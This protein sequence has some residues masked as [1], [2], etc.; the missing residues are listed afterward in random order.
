MEDGI[1]RAG[2]ARVALT[3]SAVRWR[4]PVLLSSQTGS[5]GP[6][7]ASVLFT[8][9]DPRVVDQCLRESMRTIIALHTNVRLYVLQGHC[10]FHRRRLHTLPK[11]NHTAGPSVDELGLG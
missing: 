2:L 11:D 3:A 6:P 1:W 10:A 9:E 5:L 7:V 4:S 8:C